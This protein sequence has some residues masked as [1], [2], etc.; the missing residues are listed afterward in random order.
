MA[1]LAAAELSS[2]QGEGRERWAGPGLRGH[3]G[4]LP[5]ERV[6]RGAGQSPASA[7]PRAA[8]GPGPSGGGGGG[9]AA[10][11]PGRGDGRVPSEGVRLWRSPG[12]RGRPRSVR[13]EGVRVCSLSGQEPGP[14]HCWAPLMGMSPPERGGRVLAAW[15]SGV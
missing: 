12:S 13:G 9:S 6:S 3:P 2:R 14:D 4:T 10:S 1:E 15:L 11:G 8:A 5:A 7:A